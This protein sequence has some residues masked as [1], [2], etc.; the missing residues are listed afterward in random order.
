VIDKLRRVKLLAMDVD[1]TLTD[2]TMIVHNGE[3]IKSFHAH[4]GLGIRLAMNY[5]LKI[6]WVTGNV[7][8]AVA[9]RAR[10]IG[11]TELYQGSWVKSTVIDEIAARHGISC[12]EI[13]FIGDDLNDLRAFERAGV[14]IAVANASEEVKQRADVVTERRGGEGAVR[15]AI[16]M[17]LK[18]RGEWEDAIERFLVMLDDQEAGKAGP[19]AVV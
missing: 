18:S 14:A 2:G 6:A 5:G 4:D 1:G 13:A 16:E 3:Q 10:A 11:V 15:E 8:S 9:D 12:D 7:S 17:I 19:E